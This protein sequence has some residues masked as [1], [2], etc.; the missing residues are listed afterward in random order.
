M[1][2]E[3]DQYSTVFSQKSSRTAEKI[4]GRVQVVTDAPVERWIADDPVVTAPDLGQSVRR[5]Q[6]ATQAI[7][8]Q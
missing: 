1:P 8:S 6:S 4:F 3:N 5:L 2:I 7:G